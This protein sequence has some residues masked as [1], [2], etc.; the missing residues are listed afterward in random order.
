MK[1]SFEYSNRRTKAILSEDGAYEGALEV[2]R[3]YLISVVPS[4]TSKTA[5]LPKKLNGELFAT[6]FLQMG[7]ETDKAKN[8]LN[9]LTPDIK[10]PYS[11]GID[12]FGGPYPINIAELE[13]QKEN[14]NYQIDLRFIN[15][16]GD[17]T[18]SLHLKQHEDLL[19]KASEAGFKITR[20]TVSEE[21]KAILERYRGNMEHIKENMAYVSEFHKNALIKW[22][23]EDSE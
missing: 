22:L 5:L 19:N 13:I 11:G 7:K 16:T 4:G 17:E 20:N 23:T 14:S 6:T 10:L 3:N 21:K 8:I 18:D 9:K 15:H 2:V 1:G 12:L